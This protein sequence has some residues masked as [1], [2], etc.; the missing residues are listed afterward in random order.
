MKMKRFVA[1]EYNGQTNT[2]LDGKPAVVK[3][4]ICHDINDDG[5]RPLWP[6]TATVNDTDIKQGGHWLVLE[7][8]YR[9]RE[10][11]E[12]ASRLATFGF[13]TVDGIP[14]PVRGIGCYT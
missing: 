4:T 14:M 1:G 5:D 13:K 10:S 12:I 6:I 2:T 7:A 3:F 9:L 11:Q 8:C